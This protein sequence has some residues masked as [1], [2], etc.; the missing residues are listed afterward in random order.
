MKYIRKIILKLSFFC[1]SFYCNPTRQHTMYPKMK[2]EATRFTGRFL[3]V[4]HMD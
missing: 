3:L 2:K 4:L 1:R